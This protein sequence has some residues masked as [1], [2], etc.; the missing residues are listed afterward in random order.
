M[1][2]NLKLLWTDTED[3]ITCEIWWYRKDWICYV[4]DVINKRTE[5]Y[6]LTPSPTSPADEDSQPK[7]VE[8]SEKNNPTLHEEMWW[9]YVDCPKCGK[10]NC[11]TGIDRFCPW[12][13][14][15][16]KWIA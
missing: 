10:T 8:I 15:K 5:D 16:I 13:W 7:E 6:N 3:W 14:A 12:C 11:W 4:K 1:T 9:R 2:A